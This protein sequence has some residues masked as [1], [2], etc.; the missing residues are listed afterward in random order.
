[1]IVL[2]LP[3][4]L[5][6]QE[7]PPVTFQHEVHTTALKKEGCQSC[8][9]QDKKKQMVTRFG[10]VTEVKDRDTLIDIYHDRCLGCHRQRRQAGEKTGPLTCGA[11]HRKTPLPRIKRQAMRMN[12]ALHYRHVAAEKGRCATCHH[13][14]DRKQKKVVYKKGKEM[15][16][17]ICHKASSYV[18]KAA[19]RRRRRRK[20]RHWFKTRSLRRAAHRS[21]V[22]CHLAR[23]KKLAQ[24]GKTSKKDKGLPQTGPVLC[25]GCHNK[26]QQQQ[27]E[28]H[29]KTF[30]KKLG[31]FPRLKR[32]QPDRLWIHAPTSKTRAVAFNHLFHEK[33][34]KRCSTCHHK[35]IRPC[36]RCHTPQ[37]S[38]RGRN[39]TLEKAYHAA[40]SQHSCVGCHN[41]VTRQP[42]CAG[43]HH[44][45][46]TA[47]AQKRSCTHCHNG[48]APQA[49]TQPTSR[50]ARSPASLPATPRLTG[51]P[52]SSP[53]FP[54]EV[55]IGALAKEYKPSKLPHRK[56]VAALSK[57]IAQSPLARTFHGK[58]SLLC[59][60]C[61]HHSPPG[62][63]PQPCRSCHGPKAHPTRDKPG[64][65]VAYHRQCI[66][67][68]EKMSLKTGCTTCHELARPSATKKKVALKRK[69]PQ[70]TKE[71]ETAQTAKE[72]KK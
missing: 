53:S 47:Q 25:R 20:K 11:C 63:K 36:R 52:P 8:H 71:G 4:K 40:R 62:A 30:V 38:P 43:C 16:C 67:C 42:K 65:F 18:K 45:I 3:E 55:T 59:A 26:R 46:V 60:G 44:A 56:I 21:C 17:N 31:R 24:K 15:A 32:G 39:I 27:I 66:G 2:R 23:A 12:Y 61:H 49:T 33:Q 37:G 58:T 68:H 7:R 69:T 57:A 14:Y 28:T 70:T 51:L 41:R 10:R 5:G 6:P 19:Q 35:T 72:G 22:R 54:K 9:L 13:S 34:T 50:L 48:P 64:L 29:N 1:M